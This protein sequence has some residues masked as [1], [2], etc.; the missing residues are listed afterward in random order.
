M[1]CALSEVY[2]YKYVFLIAPEKD[3]ANSSIKSG[4]KY[5]MNFTFLETSAENLEFT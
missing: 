4:T 3:I 5:S 2:F 1:G